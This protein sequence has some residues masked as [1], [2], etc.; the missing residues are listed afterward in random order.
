MPSPVRR[1]VAVAA[2][3]A[4]LGLAAGALASCGGG[5]PAPGRKA[6]AATSPTASPSRPPVRP[7]KAATRG[8]YVALGDSFTS[9]GGATAPCHR[10]GA[11]YPHLVAKRFTFAAAPA[12]TACDGATIAALTASQKGRPPQIAPLTARTSLVTVQIG[13]NDLGFTPVLATCVLQ[14]AGSS[15]C[16]AQEP[17]IRHRVTKLRTGLRAALAEIRTNA[18]RARVLVL[19]YPHLFPY[20]PKRTAAELAPRDQRW[21]NDMT[22]VANEAVR[23]VAKSA[24]AAVK[25]AGSVEYVDVTA[26]LS[27]HELGR[28]DSYVHDLDVDFQN[29]TVDPKS[30]HPTDAG[31]KRMAKAVEEQVTS[32][33]GRPL[34]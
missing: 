14:S 30:F 6:A 11:A 31:Q 12:Y 4:S 10:S 5:T 18:P 22:N 29:F 15:A 32:G 17:D 3:L 2:L 1:R 34:R 28:P 19:G 20:R 7:V 16:R 9:G 23:A 25:G 8:G 26:A 21:L 13:G 27:G 33:P 24:D